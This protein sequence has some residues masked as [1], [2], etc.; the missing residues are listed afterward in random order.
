VKLDWARFLCALMIAGLI[1]A[2]HSSLQAAATTPL[3]LEEV[4][5]GIYSVRRKFVG[6]NA[7]VIV[8]DRD[9]IVV[10]T[11]ASPAGARGTLA[12]IREITGKPVRYV[13]N[14]HWHTDHFV[15]NQAY[16]DAFPD[17]VEF[18]SHETVR[19]DIPELAV[20]QLPIAI[21]YI[22]EDLEMA[23]RMMMSGVDEHSV[24]LSEEEKVR[25]VRFVDDQGKTIQELDSQP[26]ILPDLTLRRELT[27]HRGERQIQV[28]FLGRGHTRGDV[29]VYLPQDKT[30]VAGDLLTYPTLHVGGSS[31]PVEWLA[32]LRAL[33]ELDFEILIPG[34]GE[35]VR[36]RE[37]LELIIGI[38]E[39]VVEHVQTGVDQGLKFAEIEPQVSL[40]DVY[41]QWVGDDRERGEIF[42]EAKE[43]V[44][45][46]LGR[47]YLE[48]TGRLD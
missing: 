15:G 44:P 38:L 39:Q 17:Q 19:E 25:L 21:R 36:D 48:L 47:A 13:V 45:D 41:G 35:V 1:C 6:S 14:T 37:Y 11:H 34:H 43:F 12:A 28:R 8:T 5:E 31:R 46:A 3:E 23:T 40:E 32:S 33:A 10:D 22:R 9:V 16:L 27:L 20:E 18:I 42:E 30:V 26:F 2:P 24:L 7:A 4:T 29:V